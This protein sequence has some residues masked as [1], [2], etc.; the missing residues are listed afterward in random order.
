MKKW[1]D[2]IAAW[3]IGACIVSVG[4]STILLILGFLLLGIKEVYG[5]IL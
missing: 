4:I 1:F 3:I 2:T 5:K